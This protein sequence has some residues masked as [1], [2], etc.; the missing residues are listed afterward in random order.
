ML[1]CVKTGRN[2]TMRHL[3]RTHRVQVGW[4]HEQYKS[5]QFV[6]AHESGERMPPDIFTKMFSDSNKWKA[7]RQLINVVLPSEF[8]KLMDDNKAIYAE[9]QER[10]ALVAS[11]AAPDGGDLSPKLATGGVEAS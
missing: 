5:G 1:Q 4:I 8:R 7:A 11:A 10:P 6:F 2:P 9:I 3:Q